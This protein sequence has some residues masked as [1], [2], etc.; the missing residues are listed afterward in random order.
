[1]CFWSRSMLV[2]LSNFSR[3]RQTMNEC[4]ERRGAEKEN[5]RCI[6]KRVHEA[7]GSE[8]NLD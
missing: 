3:F 8:E 1:M 2:F 4:L 7:G 5:K 6:Y